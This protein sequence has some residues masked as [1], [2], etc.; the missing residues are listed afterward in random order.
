MP[1]FVDE[2]SIDKGI[3]EYGRTLGSLIY[4]KPEIS[5]GIRSGVGYR[6][7]GGDVY[8]VSGRYVLRDL[9]NFCLVVIF[10]AIMMTL[11]YHCF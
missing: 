9:L 6:L 1:H 4:S 8:Q 10:P 7:G 3:Q 2:R 5:M 11:W